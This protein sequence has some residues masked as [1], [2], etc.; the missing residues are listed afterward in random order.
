[1]CAGRQV[2]GHLGAIAWRNMWC[3]ASYFHMA[4]LSV[5]ADGAIVPLTDTSKPLVY[6]FVPVRVTCDPTGHTRW[7]PGESQPPR[8]KFEIV[9]CERDGPAMTKALVHCSNRWAPA[10][11]SHRR[12]STGGGPSVHFGDPCG[13]LRASACRK[14]MASSDNVAHADRQGRLVDGHVGRVQGVHRAQLLVANAQE[15]E[16]PR[17]LLEI[18]GKVLAAHDG[19]D[20]DHVARPH[21]PHQGRLHPFSE[22]GIVPHGRHI[23]MVRNLGRATVGDGGLLDD[24]PEEENCSD[25]CSTKMSMTQSAENQDH[26]CSLKTKLSKCRSLKM[27]LRRWAND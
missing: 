26:C 24:P 15:D 12:N 20:L 23:G 8:Y 14:S 25:Q 19:L 7:E 22:G 13:G 2:A 27:K 16:F 10:T 1:M 11:S 17:H 18:V 9:D 3:T 6:R 4:G 5:A 21:R